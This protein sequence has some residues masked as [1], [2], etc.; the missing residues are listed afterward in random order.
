MYKTEVFR[1]RTPRL[2]VSKPIRKTTLY[3]ATLDG[4]LQAVERIENSVKYQDILIRS[5]KP[6]KI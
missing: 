4:L 3:A 5:S 6:Q 1:Y 2:K